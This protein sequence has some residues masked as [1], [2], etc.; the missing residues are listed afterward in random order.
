MIKTSE[1]KFFALQL[2]QFHH[3][4]SSNAFVLD[5]CKIHL[6]VDCCYRKLLFNKEEQMN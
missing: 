6:V 1:T 3:L 4:F 2:T 5:E